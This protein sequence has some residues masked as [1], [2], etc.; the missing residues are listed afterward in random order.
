MNIAELKIQAKQKVVSVTVLDVDTGKTKNERIDL[1]EGVNFLFNYLLPAHRIIGNKLNGRT[2][3]I[4]AGTA[5]IFERSENHRNGREYWKLTIGMQ[6]S[7]E[8]RLTAKN[9]VLA[10]FALWGAKGLEATWIEH[11]R[12]GIVLGVD[13]EK[14]NGLV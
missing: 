3:V 14:H 7:P 4:W 11:E 5:I 1:T 8:T 13:F 9:R 10:A 2:V 6:M 12:G